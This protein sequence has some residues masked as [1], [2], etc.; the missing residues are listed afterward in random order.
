[1]LSRFLSAII[2]D[3]M[4][5]KKPVPGEFQAAENGLI[6]WVRLVC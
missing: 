4:N 5:A 6:G 1:M 2:P 3:E